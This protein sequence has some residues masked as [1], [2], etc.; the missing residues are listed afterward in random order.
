MSHRNS[1]SSHETINVVNLHN[2]RNNNKRRQETTN[3]M[4][5]RNHQH[6]EIMAAAIHHQHQE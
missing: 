4:N 6:Q 2:S 1:N 5:L 3:V